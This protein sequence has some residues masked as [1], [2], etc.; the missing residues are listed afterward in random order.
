MLENN[1]ELKNKLP[2]KPESNE[3]FKNNK[4]WYYLS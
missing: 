4:R 3:V 2:I 1:E